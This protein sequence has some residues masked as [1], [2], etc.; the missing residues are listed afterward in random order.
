MT[1][2]EPL[3][4][5]DDYHV[6]FRTE[7][8]L[9]KAVDGVSFTLEAGKTLGIVGESGLGQVGAQP[10]DHGS[11]RELPPGRDRVGPLRR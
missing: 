3:L 6:G 11:R 5:V 8:G 1:T 4:V 9:A 7:R 2:T 10:L